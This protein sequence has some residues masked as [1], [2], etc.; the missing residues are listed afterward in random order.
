[1]SPKV[2]V[3]VT[4]E[5][6]KVLALDTN[7]FIYHF[8]DNPAYSTYTE[9][10]FERIESGRVRAVTSALTLH[11]ILT[12]ARKA[13]KPD[14]V[15]LY[16]NLLG[17]FPNILFVPFDARVADISSDLRAR[18]G[19]RTPD[20]IQVATAIQQRA[21]SFVTNDAGLRRIKEIRVTLPRVAG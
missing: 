21:D 13:G 2:P 6:Q 10:L 17:S 1:M 8:E 18:Y 9:N 15:A 12:G 5:R 14:L 16:R 7:I 11:E 4:A 3:R 19:I 20:A